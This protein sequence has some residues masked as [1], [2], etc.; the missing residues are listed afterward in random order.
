[1]RM[2]P[3]GVKVVPL[4]HTHTHTHTHTHRSSALSTMWEHNKNILTVTQEEWFSTEFSH[5]GALIL[6]FPASRSVRNKF[7]SFISYQT[8]G[9]FLYQSKWTKIDK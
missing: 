4:K 8:C 2:K 1:M 3:S 6:D 5:A 7:L 9:I